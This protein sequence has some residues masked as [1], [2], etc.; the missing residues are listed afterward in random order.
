MVALECAGFRLHPVF[1]EKLLMI[2]KHG[3]KYFTEIQLA[4]F[5]GNLLEN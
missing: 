5:M 3:I 1:L 2:Q 4:G